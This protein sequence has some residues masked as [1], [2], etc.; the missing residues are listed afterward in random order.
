M[1]KLLAGISIVFSSQKPLAFAK[2][3]ISSR[4]LKPQSGFRSFRDLSKAT[5]DA[6]VGTLG[7]V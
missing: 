5:F 6:A 2:F 1:L 4:L 7:R 3:E